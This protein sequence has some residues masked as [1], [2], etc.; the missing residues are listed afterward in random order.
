MRCRK[1]G[2]KLLFDEKTGDFV[3]DVCGHSIPTDLPMALA[4]E[5][6]FNLKAA[7]ALNLERAKS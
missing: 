5:K 1:C 4:N 7:A 3:C 6:V 2:S